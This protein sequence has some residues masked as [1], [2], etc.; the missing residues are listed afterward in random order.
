M[1][2]IGFFMLLFFIAYVAGSLNSSIMAFRFMSRDDPR[3]HGSKN[4]GATN[5]Y[6]QAG[7]GWA[8][9]VLILDMGRAIVV[10]LLA[11][12][13]LPL[14]QV[15][16]IGLGLILGNRFP[17]FYNFN[18]GKGVA[19]Y[20]GFTFAL[21]PTWAVLGALVW[22]SAH[23]IWRTPFLSSFAMVL[24]MTAGTALGTGIHWKGGVGAFLT[25]VFIIAC[26][27]SNIRQWWG[28]DRSFQ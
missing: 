8:V 9:S 4:P 1:N 3:N 22:G 15:P 6:R 28:G 14:W 12:A 16:W 20:L 11:K 24:V 23:L 5:V 17:C 27:H 18:G 25:A 19:N 10:A 26:H 13:C 7:L 2:H 21:A